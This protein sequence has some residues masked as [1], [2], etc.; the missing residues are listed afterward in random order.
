MWKYPSKKQRE[1]NT[2]GH[3]P[4][5]SGGE[6]GF[7]LKAAP[8]PC[9]RL[10]LTAVGHTGWCRART[11]QHWSLCCSV[12]D[13][14]PPLIWAAAN[15]RQFWQ[16][17]THLVL[18]E[19]HHRGC[20]AAFYFLLPAPMSRGPQRLLVSVGELTLPQT[21]PTSVSHVDTSGSFCMF[22]RCPC[23]TEPLLPIAVTSVTHPFS[24]FSSSLS[25]S[26]PCLTPASWDHVL[27]KSPAPRALSQSLLLGRPKSE[28]QP[29]C[30]FRPVP[31]PV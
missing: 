7:V 6:L 9:R 2:A 19:A 22:L 5:P 10:D 24:G 30:T 29:A 28:H 18:A 1:G 8:L 3:R 13:P 4:L 26:P 23:R 27:N 12:T 21:I 25:H 20:P 14:C 31:G 17:K 15:S 16:G 11:P